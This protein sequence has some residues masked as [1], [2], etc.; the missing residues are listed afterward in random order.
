MF[1]PLTYLEWIAGRPDAAAHD[2]GSSDLRARP[3]DDD[4][5]DRRA[6]DAV[7]PD[8]LVGLPDPPEGTT[9]EAQLAAIYGRSRRS[10]RVTAGASHAN[11]LV[12]MAITAAADD[13][14]V[15]VESPGYEPQVV[16]PAGFGATVDRFPRGPDGRLDPER[17]ADAITAE[18]DLVVCTNRHNPTGA[19]ADRATLAETAALAGEVGATLLVDEVYAPYATEPRRGAFGGVTAAGL[20]NAVVVSSLTKFHGLGGLRIGWIVADGSLADRLDRAAWHL[21]VVAEPSRALA[22]RALHHREALAERSRAL[23]RANHALLADFVDG[24]TDLSG[25]VREGCPFALLAHDRAAGDRVSEAAWEA[26]VLVV[27]GRFFEVPG[28]VRVALGHDPE[29]TEAA[30]AA[31]GEV[32]DGL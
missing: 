5:A 14:R 23:L 25:E 13:P 22:R 20:P 17:V 16:T 27:P 31:F 2:L 21:P 15:L 28:A 11:A 6:D 18:T 8:A 3:D 32:L 10:V 19:L 30:L 29:T 9:L 12:A 26:G 24:R 1:Q 4:L 7:V